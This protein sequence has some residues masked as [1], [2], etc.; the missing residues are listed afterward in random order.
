MSKKGIKIV[1]IGGGSSY[2]PELMEGFIA[3]YEQMP[4]REIW[5]VDVL[6]GQ[7]RLE[8]IGQ[9]AQRMWDASP[10]EVQIKCTLNRREALLGADFVTTQFRVGHLEA[11][12]KDE[13]IPFSYGLLGQETNGAG[14]IFNALRTIPVALEIIADMK[15]LCP[16]AWMINF[17][18]PSGMVTEA[19]LNYG[20][21]EKVIGLCNVPISS[22]TKE[23]LPFDSSRRPFTYRFAGIN[24]FHY[25]RVYDHQ[26]KEVTAEIIENMNNGQNNDP[27]NIHKEPFLKKQLEAMNVIPCGYH[28]YYYRQE[29]M[30]RHGLEEYQTIGTR[31]EQV[32]KIED[33]LFDLY[34]DT[35]LTQKPELLSK[36]GGAHYSTAA[37]ETMASIYADKQTPM[38]VLTRNN[39]AV[40]DLDL[41][42]VVEVSS[43]IGANGASPLAFGRLQPAER[44][45]LQLM[46]NMELCVCEAAVK[47]DYGLVLQAFI[48]NPLIPA[49]KTA[50]Q[51]LNELM[52]AHK[53]YLPQFDRT[54]KELE[55]KGVTIKDAKSKGL[56]EGE[57]V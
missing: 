45:W 28:R 20:K 2:T 31:A 38:V 19:I 32:S 21:W 17:A 41:E 15:E 29:E 1:T 57:E 37:C 44:G 54:I 25:H 33:K 26:G 46:K 56:S 42:N 3:R 7:E 22:M 8:I 48:M 49:G 13:R 23:P 10:Y 27:K 35:S 39:G 5:L 12:I 40:P 9:L 18:N 34:K 43:I 47:G 53:K 55:A 11:R 52:I 51:V 16:D 36:R 30:L 6:E 4:I 24:H 14:G 50:Q